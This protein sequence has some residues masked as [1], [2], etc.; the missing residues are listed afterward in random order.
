M[1][2]SLNFAVNALSIASIFG[3]V[4]FVIALIW[5]WKNGTRLT[6]RLIKWLIILGCLPFAAYANTLF[7]V[8]YGDYYMAQALCTK[9][10]DLT[11]TEACVKTKLKEF[12]TEGK[13]Y[14][15]IYGK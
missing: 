13:P 14:K 15:V 5:L 3:F 11:A 8:D 1:V 12:A 2:L 10:V 9:S 6:K 4:G 7:S